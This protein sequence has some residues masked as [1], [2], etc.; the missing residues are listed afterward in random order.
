[1]TDPAAFYAAIDGTWPAA[2]ITRAGP[3]TIRA[4][5]GG[6]KRVSAAT[7]DGPV[8]DLAQAE[9]AMR[10]LNQTPLF[11]VRQGEDAL[12]LLSAIGQELNDSGKEK[13]IVSVHRIAA[14]DGHVDDSEIEYIHKLGQAMGM[15]PAHV[16]GVLAG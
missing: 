12:E 10:S 14:A 16:R 13:V 2:A 7:A 4:G 3:W 11:M 9:T 5:Q 8:T 1:M 15:S 6:G